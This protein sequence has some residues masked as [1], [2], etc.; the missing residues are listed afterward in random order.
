MRR[1]QRTLALALVGLGAIGFAQGNASAL[2]YEYVDING[3][4]VNDV[5][6]LDRWH[7]G[8]NDVSAFDNDNNGIFDMVMVDYNND[9]W[10]EV[11]FYDL[12]Q[13]GVFDAMLGTEIFNQAGKTQSWT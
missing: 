12:N 8:L 13:N 4:N 7:D 11:V 3:D 2:W 5:L 10:L 9:N 1:L 6:L